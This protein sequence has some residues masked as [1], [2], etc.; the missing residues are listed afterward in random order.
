MS[1]H[2]LEWPQAVRGCLGLA[3]PLPHFNVDLSD[4]HGLSKHRLSD[5]NIEL[6]EGGKEQEL[7]ARRSKIEMCNAQ[8]WYR[9]AAGANEP[10]SA[11]LPM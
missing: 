2:S 8:V 4:L 10:G 11:A 1:Y 3:S 9:G 5:F 6:G 7:Q